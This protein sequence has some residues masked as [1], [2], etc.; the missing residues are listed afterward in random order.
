MATL[1]VGMP[2]EEW[3]SSLSIWVRTLPV[4]PG[5]FVDLIPLSE[6]LTPVDQPLDK[7]E[8]LKP[9]EMCVVAL[10]YISPTLTLLIVRT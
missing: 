9:D 2:R 10:L 5:A 1:L 3:P 7:L 6:M 8:D 4:M